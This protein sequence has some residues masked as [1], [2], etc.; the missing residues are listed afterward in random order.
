MVAAP[1][2]K[3]AYRLVLPKDGGNAR[4]QGWAVVEN[5]TG[6]DWN[7]I[8]LVLVSGNPVALHQPLY[9]A[10]FADRVEV[11]VTTTARLVP[12]TDDADD[13]RF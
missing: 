7:D 2:W 3:T 10:F 1:I 5:L 11:P 4:L 6:G 12:R 8:D 13:R 9:T